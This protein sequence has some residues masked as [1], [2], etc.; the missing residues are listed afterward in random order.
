M[1][2]QGRIAGFSRHHEGSAQFPRL[3]H[4]RF[5][6]F[7]GPK[8][9]SVLAADIG[10]ELFDGQLDRQRVR[11]IVLDERAK[12]WKERIDQGPPL[13]A[14]EKRLVRD[15]FREMMRQMETSA[16]RFAGR[17][18]TQS[19]AVRIVAVGAAKHYGVKAVAKWLKGV[20]RPGKRVK[21]IVYGGRVISYST[22]LVLQAAWKSLE[23]RQ[24]EADR[25]IDALMKYI[26]KEILKDAAARGLTSWSAAEREERD[27]QARNSAGLELG[28]RA[29]ESG[30]AHRST[31]GRR[32]RGRTFACPCLCSR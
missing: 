16:T 28:Q 24:L 6:V 31:S 26:V 5:R 10:L 3:V 9:A 4:D 19:G 14:D 20:F 2:E 7:L 32:R 25:A 13:S 11:L 18:L 21:E 17:A 12:Q 23:K 22:R 15:E 30:D 1:I 29:L 27:R 8:D